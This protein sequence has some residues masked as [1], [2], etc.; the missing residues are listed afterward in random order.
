MLISSSILIFSMTRF[1]TFVLTYKP[2]VSPVTL[3]YALWSLRTILTALISI[4]AV[5][6]LWIGRTH[7]LSWLSFLWHQR[8]ILY[9]VLLFL[10]S[11]YLV[12]LS[13]AVIVAVAFIVIGL[14]AYTFGW[15]LVL[16]YAFV[17]VCFII[18]N[19]YHNVISSIVL[20]TISILY[21]LTLRFRSHRWF[22]AHPDI[23][24]PPDL[25]GR[26]SYYMLIG[27]YS[28]LLLCAYVATT[29]G[30]ISLIDLW[31]EPNAPQHYPRSPIHLSHDAP[32]VGLALSGGGYRAAAMH[33]GVLDALDQLFGS[34]SSITHI[35]AVSGGAIVGSFY[36]AGGLPADFIDVLAS[37]QLNLERQL[38]NIFNAIRL[39]WPVVLRGHSY[40][41]LPP[42]SRSDAHTNE[43]TRVLLGDLTFERLHDLRGP[44][45]VIG[46]TDLISGQ[47]LGIVYN[48]VF[49]SFL[50]ELSD[51]L[52]YGY[53]PRR[54]SNTPSDFVATSPTTF[55]GSE[56]LARVVAAS[57]ALPVVFNAVNA[58]LVIKTP[59]GERDQALLLADGGLWDNSA[60]SFLLNASELDSS[61][62]LDLVLASD[63]GTA[64]KGAAS[65]SRFAEATRALDVVYASAGTRLRMLVAQGH[66]VIVFAPAVFFSIHDSSPDQWHA[67]AKQAI[68]EFVLPLVRSGQ[69]CEDVFTAVASDA[70]NNIVVKVPRSLSRPP[71]KE[72][73]Q[74]LIHG[75]CDDRSHDELAIGAVTSALAADFIECLNVFDSTSTLQ[76]QFTTGEALALYRLGRY[77]VMFNRA[78]L[79]AEIQNIKVRLEK[80]SDHSAKTDAKTD[81][82]EVHISARKGQAQKHKK[83]GH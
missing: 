81:A 20:L 22:T 34:T 53:S 51:S 57:A 79:V 50:P 26:L 37:G 66:R 17:T 48:G 75:A 32:H 24:S 28:I 63:A 54:D 21:F 3:F 59:I 16:Q 65:I 10:A 76:E 69:T 7:F 49:R 46:T 58:T 71:A 8:P 74:T 39:P 29:W 67:R 47:A 42:L 12:T 11:W 18:P 77:L 40:S 27:P 14:A 4:V 2:N 5:L 35:S 82:G 30:C 23:K 73:M 70:R 19:H 33:A 1:L 62:Y 44:A 60:L 61:W 38:S 83:A 43:L 52:S 68:D 41:L 78:L 15:V 25:A 31:S 9:L 72:T 80:S 13:V 64:F 6:I 45:L 55:P 56:R 36:A